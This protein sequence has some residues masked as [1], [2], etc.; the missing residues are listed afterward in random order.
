MRLSFLA[1]AL[2]CAVV[3]AGAAHAQTREEFVRCRAIE[4]DARRLACYDA[5][6]LLS[7]PR[8]KYEAVSV[9]E[10]RDF[11]LSYRGRFVEVVGWVVAGERFL[12]LKQSGDATQSLP[13]DIRTLSR[14]E[15]QE[16]AEQCG[17]G[18]EA[19]VQGRVAPV[20]FTTGIVADEIVVH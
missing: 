9:E 15:Q 12:V 14:A 10:L 6:S 16:L 13:V 3:F 19:T 17:G 18:C 20:N 7:S 4:D 1:C 8:S 11:A 2:A 5:I